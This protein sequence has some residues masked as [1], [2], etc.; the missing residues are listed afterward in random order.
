V[1]VESQ[2]KT[3]GGLVVAESGEAVA[4]RQGKVVAVGPG[5]R[6]FNSNP[7]IL[8]NNFL[9]EPMIVKVGDTVL[10]NYGQEVTL[11]GK[12]YW[13]TS[14]TDIAVIFTT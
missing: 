7:Q 1:E 3:A 5:K 12:K 14:E 11:D 6:V 4:F 9:D 10:F 13:L 8:F 2:S